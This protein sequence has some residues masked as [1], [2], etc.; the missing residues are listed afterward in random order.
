MTRTVQIW[1]EKVIAALISSIFPRKFIENKFGFLLGKLYRLTEESYIIRDRERIHQIDSTASREQKTH[2]NI[3]VC[4][5]VYKYN[6][7][8]YMHTIRCD[9]PCLV[10]N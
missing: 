4:L 2:I 10:H 5:Y 3:C 7:S 1:S 8:T 6:I 9:C